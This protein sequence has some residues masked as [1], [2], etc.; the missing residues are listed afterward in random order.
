MQLCKNTKG[1]GACAC[2][3]ALLRG[4]QL[5]RKKFMVDFSLPK[6]PGA[7]GPREMEGLKRVSKGFSEWSD[8]FSLQPLQRG[9]L[10]A[11]CLPLPPAPT[12]CLLK[13]HKAPE[14]SQMH[15]ISKAECVVKGTINP[16][17]VDSDISR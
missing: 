7:Q 3:S 16:S 15:P 4:P 5:P 10:G 14:S 9:L 12:R 2:Q 17:M 8:G 11:L 6:G 13:M 1:E